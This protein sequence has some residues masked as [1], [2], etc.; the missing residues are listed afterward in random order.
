MHSQIWQISSFTGRMSLFSRH[1]THMTSSCRPNSLR[2]FLD[3]GFP[4]GKSRSYCVV[5]FGFVFWG[6]QR[7]SK[8]VALS[9]LHLQIHPI[10][11]R[12]DF[13]PADS[14]SGVTTAVQLTKPGFGR[15]NEPSGACDGTSSMMESVALRAP[16]SFFSSEIFAGLH[17]KGMIKMHA[18]SH[19]GK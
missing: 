11:F 6:C 9:F 13:C 7:R 8:F 1:I 18:K 15:F 19:Y 14:T 2:P 16:T 4:R 17:R 10:L 3:K 5:E 12:P